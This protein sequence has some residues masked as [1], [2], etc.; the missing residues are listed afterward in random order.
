METAKIF[1]NG[2]SRAVRLP[3]SLCFSDDVKEVEVY[4]K[5]DMIILKPHRPQWSSFAEE[6]PT[7]PEDFLDT[8]ERDQD[9][10]QLRK[11]WP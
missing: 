6:A 7:V 5:G 1:I 9:Q 8:D 4:R 10:P 3:K 2:R 11:E